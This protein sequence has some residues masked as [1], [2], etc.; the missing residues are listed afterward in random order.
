M[1]DV[2][3][4]VVS[5]EGTAQHAERFEAMDWFFQPRSPVVFAV[6]RVAFFAGLLAHFAPALLHLDESFGPTA[7][8]L[9]FLSAWIFHQL[10]RLPSWLL[11]AGATIT[12]LACFS[13]SV[14]FFSRV[15]ALLCF[16]GTYAFASFNAL[17]FFTLA[18]ANAWAV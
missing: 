12:L 6:F 1:T 11:A 17:P 8:R 15:S 2:A 4:H 9:P 14:G 3:V 16:A 18:L 13:A 7:V 5:R 10:P